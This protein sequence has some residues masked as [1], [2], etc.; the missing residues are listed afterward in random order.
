VA[1]KE[2]NRDETAYFTSYQKH[3][4]AGRTAAQARGL[5]EKESGTNPRMSWVGKLKGGVKK[6]LE[7]ESA[8]TK[9]ISDQLKKSGLTDEQ[10]KRLK[11]K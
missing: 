1:D 3:R 5:A 8:R 11:G 4:S 10:I 2:Y 7:R 6:E 9:G